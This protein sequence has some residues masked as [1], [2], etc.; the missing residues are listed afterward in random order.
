MMRKRIRVGA[1]ALVVGAAAFLS[2]QGTPGTD[3][4]AGVKTKTELEQLVAKIRSGELKGPQMLFDRDK[5]PYQI[6]TSFIEKRKGAADIHGADDEIFVI[7]DGAATA[8][9]GGD[10]TDKKPSGEHEF[11][12]T[13]IAG[14][15]RRP[16]AAGD[17]V[18]VPRGTPHQMDAGSGEVLYLVIK[19]KSPR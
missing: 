5:G 11:R 9:L 17:L 7:L 1:S 4:L 18:S 3:T 16:V 14:G 13:T 10:V 8:T 6:Y 2:A 15:V 12:G 19:I